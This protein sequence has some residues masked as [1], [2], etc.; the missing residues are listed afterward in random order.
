MNKTFYIIL[1]FFLGLSVA[2]TLLQN[3]IRMQLGTQMFFLDSFNMWFLTLSITTLAGSIFLL[4]YYH[5]KKYRFVFIIGIISVVCNFGYAILGFIILKF[6]KFSNY[7]I[8]V[9]L[10]ALSTGIIYAFSLLLPKPEKGIWLK[11]A[12]FFMI[13]SSVIYS[14]T[15]VWHTIDSSAETNNKVEKISEWVYLGSS[16]IYVSLIIHFI[17]EL[18]RISLNNAGL[19]MRKGLRT[20]SQLAAIV[21]FTCMLTFG[22]KIYSNCYAPIDWAKRNFEKTKQLAQLCELR[23]FVNSKGEILPYRILKP[24][25]YDPTKKYPLV[26]SLPY[27]GQPGTDW[28]KQIEGA[29]AAE[30]L[31]TDD[32]RKK[33]PAF[34]FIP[35]CPPGGGWGGIPYYPS[36]DSLVFDAISSLNA[37]FNIDSNRRYVT[38]L[39]RGGYGAWNFICKRPDLFAAA[40]PVCGGADTALASRAISV[41]VWAFHG[42]NYK[43]V[44][45]SGSRNMIN[46][47][48]NAGGHPRYTEFPDE[49]HNIWYK[50]SITP[51]LWDWLFSQSRK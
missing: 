6:H 15:L 48:K 19:Q 8:S 24:L 25:H 49:A 45:V 38:G 3:I 26:V 44:P 12:G 40:I 34:I 43:N 10:I 11:I 21:S 46:A 28:I 22:I 39:S 2:S 9:L 13:A 36:I 32:N 14:S 5:F 27:G 42:K 18:K 16:M 1:I 51:G 30:L 37:Q 4:K 23:T 35:H 47:M 50:T 33:Y 41:A 7:N 31:S 17:G 29:V 20:V